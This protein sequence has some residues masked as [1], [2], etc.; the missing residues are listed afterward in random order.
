MEFTIISIGRLIIITLGETFR[1]AHIKIN[2]YKIYMKLGTVEKLL[3]IGGAGLVVFVIY[4]MFIAPKADP[5]AGGKKID[6]YISEIKALEKIDPEDFKKL[7]NAGLD[8][9][10]LITTYQEHKKHV[11]VSHAN[12]GR[13]MSYF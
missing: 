9:D 13:Y 10:K 5:V 8:M 2:I 6:E 11:P 1:A 3:I 7:K 4:K 12:L